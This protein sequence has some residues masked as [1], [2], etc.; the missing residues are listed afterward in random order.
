MKS[1][2]LLYAASLA[3]VV[4]A[5]AHSAKH[6]TWQTGTLLHYGQNTFETYSQVN[7]TGHETP[8]TTYT[9]EIESGNL[10]YFADRT[11][12]WRWQRFPQVTEN[13]PISWHLKGRREMVIRDDD[14][15][16]FTVTITKKK[17]L[18]AAASR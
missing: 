15:R 12:N 6:Q 18:A 14:G 4:P 3:V 17:M 7:G 10:I 9:V 5:V 2:W 11:L 8:H 1:R 13:G 16:Q